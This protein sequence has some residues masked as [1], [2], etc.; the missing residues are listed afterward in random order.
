MSR[1]YARGTDTRRDTKA[2]GAVQDESVSPAHERGLFVLGP[3]RIDLVAPCPGRTDE[4]LQAPSVRTWRRVVHWWRCSTIFGI[5]LR[6]GAIFAIAR[7][8]HY[9][10]GQKLLPNN[11]IF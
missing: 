1:P 9:Y 2:S 8:K 6:R 4:G 3:W 7:V 11:T 5:D 10:F